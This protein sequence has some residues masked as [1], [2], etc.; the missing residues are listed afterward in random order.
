MKK[1]ARRVEIR[2]S[3]P[4]NRGWGATPSQPAKA[5]EWVIF[6]VYTDGTEESET[7]AA[8]GDHDAMARAGTRYALEGGG[9][10]TFGTGWRWL[11]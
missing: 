2:P 1:R 10:A 6:V 8:F 11:L 5:A 9:W 4:F 7:I 3:D